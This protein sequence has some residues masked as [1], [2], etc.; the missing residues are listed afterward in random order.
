MTGIDNLRV[1]LKAAVSVVNGLDALRS[2][3]LQASL[4]ELLDMDEA[5]AVTLAKDL[6]VLDLKD[7]AFEAKVEALALAGANVAAMV[8]RVLRLFIKK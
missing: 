1:T 3:D 5:E 8:L 4:V 6:Q 7:D 2:M